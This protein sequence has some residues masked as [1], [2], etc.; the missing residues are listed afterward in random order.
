MFILAEKYGFVCNTKTQYEYINKKFTIEVAKVDGK[1]I[2]RIKQFQR[3]VP[4]EVTYKLFEDLV[5]VVGFVHETFI[6]RGLEE[7]IR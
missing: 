4:S 2:V 3:F 5:D 6:D 1:Y 7:I